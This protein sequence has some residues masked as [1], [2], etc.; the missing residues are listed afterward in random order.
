MSQRN[1]GFFEEK[2]DWS[3][4]K[5]ALLG[6]Y[7]FVCFQKVIH[8]KKPIVDIDCFAGTEGDGALIK[9]DLPLMLGS[10]TLLGITLSFINDASRHEREP[11]ASTVQSR[12][13]ILRKAHEMG[14]YTWVSMEPVIIPDEALEVIRLAYSDVE[15]WK[16]VCP[17]RVILPAT[18]HF[19][20]SL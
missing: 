18:Q 20:R 15:F 10:Q 2:K 1:S 6:A 19:E 12:L 3:R 17:N 4:I 5:D 14:I 7:L 16:V 8:T 11:M 9:R 13:N